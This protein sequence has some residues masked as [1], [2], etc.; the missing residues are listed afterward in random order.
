MTSRLNPYISFDGNAREAL[1]FYH[2]VLGGELALNTY[3]E[4]GSPDDP[5]ADKIMHGAIDGDAGFA[6]MG[7]DSMPGMPYTVGNNVSISLFGDDADLLRSCWAKLTDGGE[8]MMPLAMQVW[9]DEF[10]MF[11]DKYGIV[12]MINIAPAPE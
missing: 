11:T 1:E 12:W 9:G 10:G 5:G 6:L 3:G 7:A 4:F 2:G 8:I